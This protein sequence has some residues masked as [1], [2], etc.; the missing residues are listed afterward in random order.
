MNLAGT[1]IIHYFEMCYR[2]FVITLS[3]VS[4]LT[5]LLR[6]LLLRSH[7]P[8]SMLL[9]QSWRIKY[10]PPHVKHTA[11]KRQQRRFYLAN[12]RGTPSRCHRGGPHTH[13]SCMLLHRTQSTAAC[14]LSVGPGKHT[15]HPV[16][17]VKS[18]R[19]FFSS[20]STQRA[21]SA[22]ACAPSCYHWHCCGVMMMIA[23]RK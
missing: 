8:D 3:C 18:F 5:M 19:L 10:F 2:Q 14:L 17:P 21:P 7:R 15:K 23:V 20:L 12:S 13:A 9:T 6:L 1:K 22:S 16:E 4:V 11:T